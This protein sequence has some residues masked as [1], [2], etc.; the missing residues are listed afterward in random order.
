MQI[1][2]MIGRHT[3]DRRM[4]KRVA[5]SVPADHSRGTNNYNAFLGYRGNAHDSLR[6][7]IQS[8]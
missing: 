1:L 7:S 6:S 3:Y 8:T 4:V 2:G 5:K